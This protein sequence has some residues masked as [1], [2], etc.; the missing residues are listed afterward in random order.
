[1]KIEPSF[2]PNGRES[3][4][5]TGKRDFAEPLA[6]HR[7]QRFQPYFGAHALYQGPFTKVKLITDYKD[8]S[9]NLEVTDRFTDVLEFTTHHRTK[10]QPPPSN[11]FQ[12]LQY[13]FQQLFQRL[14]GHFKGSGEVLGLKLAPWTSGRQPRRVLSID[15][16][17]DDVPRGNIDYLALSLL[18]LG[19]ADK[20]RNIFIHATDPGVGHSNDEHDRTILITKNHGLYFVPNNGS[21]G[22]LYKRLLDEGEKPLLLQIDFDKVERLEQKRLNKLDYKTPVKLNGWD[23]FA[24]A[25]GLVA[26][27]LDPTELAVKDETGNIK[28]LKPVIRHFAESTRVPRPGEILTAYALQ[29]KSFGN[30]KVNIPLS[31]AEF[32]FLKRSGRRLQVKSPESNEW[33]NIPVKEKHG[34]VPPGNLLL[35]HGSSDGVLPGTRYLEIANNMGKTNDIAGAAKLLGIG[36]MEAQPIQI[37]CI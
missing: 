27:G 34:D 16:I 7:Q 14:T 8:G 6:A 23:V 26:G 10:Q 35:Y 25:A 11:L 37:R 31:D 13:W 4:F 29:D 3:L 5:F 30:L 12:Q 9:S 33:L 22:M 36:N 2:Y 24:V 32:D 18:R 17:G 20:N 1:M 21:V 19:G 15:S 28:Q